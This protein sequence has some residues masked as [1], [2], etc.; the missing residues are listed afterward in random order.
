MTRRTTTTGIALASAACLALA[1]C[2]SSGGSTGG[3]GSSSSGGGSQTAL[4]I[5]DATASTAYT[6]NFNPFD[7]G[8]FV[9]SENTVSFMYEP[10]MMINTLKSTQAPIPWLAQKFDWTN[11]G[12]QLTIT[13]NPNAKWSDGSAL[14]SAD[15]AFTYQLVTDPKN[16]AMNLQ[17]IPAAASIT[18]PSATQVVINYATSESAN[19]V[20]IAD[21]VIVQKKQWSAISNPSSYVLPGAQAVGSGPYVLDTFSGQDVKYKANPSYWQGAPKVKE[22][23]IPLYTSNDAASLALSAG[24][25]DLAGNDI[26]NVLSTFVNKDPAHNHLY[27]SAAP[28]FPA[29][30]TVSLLLNTKSSKEPALGDANVRKAISAAL[31]RQSMAT[32]CETNYE[33]PA[34]SSGGL[35]LPIDQAAENPAT[36]NDIKS[37]PDSATVTSDMQAAGYTLTGGKWTKGG[38]QITFSIIDPNSFSDYWCDAQA[39]ATGLTKA[40]FNVTASGNYTYDTWTKAI[41]TGDFTAALHWG[42]GSTP[43]QRDQFILDYTQSAPEGTAAAGDYDRY[44]SPDATKAVQDYESAT[45][46]Q[47]QQSA[48]NEIQSVFSKDMPAIPVLYGA[49]WY[50]YN[51]SHF[52]GWPTS[53]NPYINPSPQYQAYEYLVWNLSPVS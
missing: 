19:Y 50:E 31:D 8:D 40:G 34:T 35:T 5:E 46:A 36:T 22:L 15:V 49:A 52:T 21:Q 18:E 16:S 1:A 20:A 30:N 48:L 13:L 25:I 51:D 37:S 4:V 24:D 33:L 11:S 7:A 6:D 3:G 28:Y 43:F 12:K 53:A 39:M 45:H 38:K 41:T 26:N 9:L 17:G 23:S 32:Q 42:Q 44:T 27:Q 29:S 10:L 14:T 2:S 47:D